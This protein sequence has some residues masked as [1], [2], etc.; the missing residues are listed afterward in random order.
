MTTIHPTE[1]TL[2]QDGDADMES[3]ASTMSED[4]CLS[5]SETVA[6]DGGGM[7]VKDIS[8]NPERMT[9]EMQGWDALAAAVIEQAIKDYRVAIIVNSKNQIRKL[10]QFFRSSYFNTISMIEP[11]WL[12]K[13]CK[14]KFE[15]ERDER[16][17]K[18]QRQAERK[19]SE[20]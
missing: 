1:E 2:H 19:F 17:E 10:E 16:N 20:I 5:E 8:Q 6:I 3:I 12:I 11:E 15:K 14:A 4:T 9:A 13:T 18:K 7:K